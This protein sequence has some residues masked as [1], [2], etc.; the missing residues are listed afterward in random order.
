MAENVVIDYQRRVFTQIGD[1]FRIDNEIVQGALIISPD[2]MSPWSGLDDLNP[3][4]GM[5]DHVDVV[6][7]GMG[8]DIAPLPKDIAAKLEE[9]RVPYEVM[10]SASACRTYNILLSEERRVA[11]AVLPVRVIF[12]LAD[13]PK[14]L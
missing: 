5:A 3:L 12:R 6:F 1:F 4:M 11:L 7:I 9:A 14:G 13:L 10:N 8:A 2:G